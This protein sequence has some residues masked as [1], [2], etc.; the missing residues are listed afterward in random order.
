M[1]HDAMKR[2]ILT[3]LNREIASLPTGF[4][5]T[6]QYTRTG[7]NLTHPVTVGAIA[8]VVG[9]L[10]GVAFVGI[11]VRFNDDRVREVRLD[12]IQTGRGED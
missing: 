1:K 4:F 8:R 7:N 5:S 6:F 12:D 3:T 11:D 10:P 9:Q 2:Q